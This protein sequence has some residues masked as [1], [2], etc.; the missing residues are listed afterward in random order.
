MFPLI[1]S[2]SYIIPEVPSRQPSNGWRALR[3][4]SRCPAQH[5]APFA[6][7][8]SLNVFSFVNRIRT[9]LFLKM[10]PLS[11]QNWLPPRT[12]FALNLKGGKN[13]SGIVPFSRSR[14]ES[15]FLPSFS[16]SVS[17]SPSSLLLTGLHAQRPPGLEKSMWVLEHL[18]TASWLINYYSYM[19]LLCDR[20]LSSWCFWGTERAPFTATLTLVPLLSLP[21]P[22]T[23]VL[24]TFLP[25]SFLLSIFFI[26]FT[27]FAGC[28]QHKKKPAGCMYY[29]PSY[30]LELV[31][32]DLNLRLAIDWISTQSALFLI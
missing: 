32:I 8:P 6:E 20:C 4:P 27:Q 11:W 18:I 19:E 30:P 29:G 17:Q 31:G 24:G 21:L 7:F 15:P 3:W 14:E 13:N 23:Q 26:T 12:A 28:Y 1:L 10:M 9:R 2:V 22:P 16:T 25:F 5:R